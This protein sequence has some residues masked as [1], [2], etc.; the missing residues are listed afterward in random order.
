[1]SQLVQNG[2]NTE[3]Q[4]KASQNFQIIVFKQGNEEYALHIDQIKEVVITP[5]ITKMPQ[6][7]SYIKGV[8]NIRG[9]IISIIDLEDKFGLKKTDRNE[10][11]NN[12][13]LVIQS[14]EIK[15]G[16]LVQDVPN[17]MTVAPGD[18]D[19][20]ISLPGEGSQDM[21]YIIGIIKKEARLIILIDVMKVL[22]YEG[23]LLT[24]KN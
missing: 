22:E 8:A 3:H 1:M 23:Q 19:Y 9:N 7:E 2:A 24:L 20:S 10:S 17:T 12:Y 4:S 18:L 16:L 14:E 6:V 11:G 5:P 21:D 13:T 15:A